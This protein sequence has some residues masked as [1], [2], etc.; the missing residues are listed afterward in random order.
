[1]RPSSAADDLQLIHH[2]GAPLGH[3]RQGTSAK[4]LQ[5][6]E[7]EAKDLLRLL[8]RRCDHAARSALLF[9][10]SPQAGERASRA[11]AEARRTARIINQGRHGRLQLQQ[12]RKSICA[13][14]GHGA[15]QARGRPPDILD[16]L[17]PSACLHVEEL[18]DPM[19]RLAAQEVGVPTVHEQGAV[20]A[21]RTV[22]LLHR[23][24]FPTASAHESHTVLNRKGEDEP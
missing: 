4:Q 12:V 3:H 21:P 22:C 24:C 11:H 6:C 23:R 15:R 10:M 5:K 9:H 1:M 18:P 13:T 17:Q 7:G 16:G 8:P 2:P 20:P 19:R 14:S